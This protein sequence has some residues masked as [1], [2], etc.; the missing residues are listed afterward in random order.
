VRIPLDEL[1]GK[2]PLPPTS[3]WPQGVWDIEAFQHGSMSVVLFAPQGRDHQDAHEQ[4]ELYVVLSGTGTLVLDKSR[5]PFSQGDVLFVPAR[6]RHHFES[7]T[8]DFVTWA[9]FWGPPGGEK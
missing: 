7:F 6:H 3:L 8:S 4:D 5:I 9:I 1:K 2:L